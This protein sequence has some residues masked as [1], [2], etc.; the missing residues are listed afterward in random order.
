VAEQLE[1]G[2]GRTWLR[3]LEQEFALKLVPHVGK[4][5]AKK[6]AAS[7]ARLA[8]RRAMEG[9]QPQAGEAGKAAVL[10]V[11]CCGCSEDVMVH[12]SICLCQVCASK[13]MLIAD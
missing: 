10:V 8:G 11:S 2:A 6:L 4:D 3:G 5:E 1:L 9:Q 12:E 7:L 13:T